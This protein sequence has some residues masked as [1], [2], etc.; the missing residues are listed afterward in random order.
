MLYTILTLTFARVFSFTLLR[1]YAKCWLI[2]K[3]DDKRTFE[4][5][6]KASNDNSFS[7]RTHGMQKD[8]MNVTAVILPV[9]NKNS[10]KQGIAFTNYTLEEG[11]YERLLKEHNAIIMR[12][13]GE[14]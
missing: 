5:I 7:N 8:G 4:V 9:T 6:G 3:D 2:I 14:W 10:A 13:A 1:M 11:L 12:N